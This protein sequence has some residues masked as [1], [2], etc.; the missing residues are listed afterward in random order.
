MA[1]AHALGATFRDLLDHLGTGIIH[2]DRRGRVVE[3]NVP[4]PRPPFP[5][6][7]ACGMRE[8]S[9]G[10]WMP[11]DNARLGRLV[12]ARPAEPRCTGNRRFHARQAPFPRAG[13]D[14]ARPSRDGPA[15]GP[16]RSRTWERWCW[17]PAWTRPGA[18][19]PGMIGQLLGLTPTESR[20]AVGLAEGK[21][22]PDVAAAS[23]R[24]E[25]TVRIHLKRVHRK[26]GVSRRA[27]L[28]RL[29]LSVAERRPLSASALI[30]TGSA[31]RPGRPGGVIAG[32][33]A[34]CGRPAAPT[35]LHEGR[36]C[37]SGPVAS[38]WRR[39]RS[40]ASSWTL[41][42]RNETPSPPGL[43]EPLFSI[44]AAGCA[45]L[46][47]ARRRAGPAAAT[48]ITSPSEVKDQVWGMNKGENR[49]KQHPLHP[50]ERPNPRRYRP[51]L[52]PVRESLHLSIAVLYARPKPAGRAW[53]QRRR[54]PGPPH[55]V[56]A[57]PPHRRH[58]KVCIPDYARGVGGSA[59][60]QLHDVASQR[61]LIPPGAQKRPESAAAVPTDFA[62]FTATGGT[63]SGPAALER[64]SP[65]TTRVAGRGKVYVTGVIGRWVTC[66]TDNMDSEDQR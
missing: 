63:S 3:A 22:V 53:R 25:G 29:V 36:C 16:R 58:R 27:D 54:C 21:T 26:L 9:C 30:E 59:P 20:V 4:G 60:R 13:A 17:L 28:V 37:V 34:W 43:P 46:A 5:R 50:A 31:A 11:A 51:F 6:Q 23:G 66:N 48:R 10:A 1:R 61:F 32:P 2:L 64:G 39:V 38:P 18:S 49:E 15:K 40:P 33:A 52:S 24:A 14:P 8:D 57:A 45:F 44:G 7:R 55:G 65:A 56:S 35:P 41:R 62:G 47:R 19:M 12:A 42:R